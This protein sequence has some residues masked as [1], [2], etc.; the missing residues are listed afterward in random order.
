MKPTEMIFQR[1]GISSLISATS[2][3]GWA[4]ASLIVI[5]AFGTLASGA[6]KVGSL[7]GCALVCI[8]KFAPQFG[9]FST[10]WTRLPQC[11]QIML[12][13]SFAEPG[14]GHSPRSRRRQFVREASNRE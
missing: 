6:S 1:L 14:Q 2:L 3:E 12:G 5:L 8:G 4:I 13:P 11:S 10:A 7:A 9:H